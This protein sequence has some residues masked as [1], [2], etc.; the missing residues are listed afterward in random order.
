M[1]I[2]DGWNTKAEGK[3]ISGVMGKFSFSIYK[4]ASVKLADLYENNSMFIANVFPQILQKD[5]TY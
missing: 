1:L 2:M 4:V 5:C 3:M